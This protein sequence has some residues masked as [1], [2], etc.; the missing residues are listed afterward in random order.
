M[1][2]LDRHISEAPQISHGCVAIH[3]WVFPL[4][5]YFELRPNKTVTLDRQEE[6]PQSF[7]AASRTRP[8]L[9][10]PRRATQEG[11]H[12]GLSRTTFQKC[13]SLAGFLSDSQ[14]SPACDR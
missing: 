14:S 1:L 9:A 7:T 4:I 10:C 12:P 6:S 13:R 2:I 3:N 8:W 5:C 11:N